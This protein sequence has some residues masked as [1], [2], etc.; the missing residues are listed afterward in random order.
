MYKRQDDWYDKWRHN[1]S[2]P[3]KEAQWGDSLL[4][5]IWE[6]GK[7]YTKSVT[8]SFLGAFED[9][10]EFIGIDDPD[11]RWTEELGMFDTDYASPSGPGPGA[12]GTE[13]RPES[14][15]GEHID[16]E[17][18]MGIMENAVTKRHEKL[19]EQF[20]LH[21]KTNRD[22]VDA[23]LDQRNK[24]NSPA[25]VETLFQQRQAQ[26]YLPSTFRGRGSSG[27]L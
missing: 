17:R 6:F 23:I 5:N 16:V 25:L 22:I 14:E 9:T 15:T 18:Q 3:W 12:L 26:T 4:T 1:V 27:V 21:V 2:R 19:A 11:K 24:Y 8:G 13:A 20:G 10:A 7:A